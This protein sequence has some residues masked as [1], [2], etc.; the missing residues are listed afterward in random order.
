MTLLGIM[1]DVINF[2]DVICLREHQRSGITL[3]SIP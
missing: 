1:F 3:P 2:Y